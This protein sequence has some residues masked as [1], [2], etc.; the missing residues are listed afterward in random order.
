MDRSEQLA[1]ERDARPMGQTRQKIRGRRNF[2]FH[3][4][5]MELK[6][7]WSNEPGLAFVEN[8][9][10]WGRSGNGYEVSESPFGVVEPMGR[11]DLRGIVLPERTDLR[12]VTFRP[13]DFTGAVMKQAWIELSA[14]IDACFDCAS[15]QL[16][17]ERGNIFEKCTFRGTNFRRALV[18]AHR[19]SR[20]V[21]CHFKATDFIQTGFG[22]PEFDDCCFENCT[23]SG[24]NFNGASFERCEFQGEVRG[25]WFHGG[26]L[27]KSDM[28]NYGEPRPN[29]MKCVS[30]R[31]AKLVDVAFSDGCDLS[32]VVPPEDGRH[33]VFDRWQERIKFVFEQSRG[34]PE[35][36]RRYAELYYRVH[37]TQ[38]FK[39]GTYPEKQDWYLTGVDALM[40]LCGKEAGVK[41]WESLLATK[42]K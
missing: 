39:D 4:M 25:V 21:Q 29:K 18:G 13:A 32:S 3:K 19:G 33:A 11:M 36:L 41:L 31:N 30:F 37:E 14:F 34:W 12:R 24:V 1:P 9:C 15:L 8:L 27:Y 2:D 28:E 5:R 10:R 22:R 23:F 26:F 40:N 42:T 35:P 38:P 17:T 16:V 6:K 7:R 20:F